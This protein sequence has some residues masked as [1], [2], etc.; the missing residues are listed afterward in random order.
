[1][2]PIS[3]SYLLAGL[4]LAVVVLAV[5]LA[6]RKKVDTVGL[7]QRLDVLERG[8]ERL[9]AA[10]RGEL[11]SLRTNAERSA[12][13]QRLELAESVKA[14][15]D[16]M[17][18]S[19]EQVTSLHRDK[20]DE[21]SAALAEMTRANDRRMQ[22]L[23]EVVDKNLA[24]MWRRTEASLEKIRDK[25]DK[26]L[27]ETLEQRLGESFR[28]VSERLEQV[29]HGL[30]EMQELA[31]GVGDLKK[32]LTNVKARGTWGEV[33][34][35]MLLE[36][37]LAP[38]QFERN[39]AVRPGA[40]ERVEFAIRLPGAGEGGRVLLPV[41]S[42]FPVADFQRLVD[43][44]ERGD[45]GA[46]A[47][48]RKALLKAVEENAK[49]ISDKYVVPPFTTDFAVMYL[50]VEGLYAEVLREPGVVEE[51]QVKHRVTVAGPST[52]AAFLNSLQM[53]FTTLAIQ[54]RAREVWS[55]LKAVKEDMSRFGRD[56]EAAARHIEKAG[57]TVM[58]AAR[59][60][61][62]IERRLSDVETLSCRLQDAAQQ[63]EGGTKGS[64][65][66]GDE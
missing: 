66:T 7:A 3:S 59:R 17:R 55:L 29:Q 12:R 50:P 10:L 41:D 20:L 37:V 64:P 21:V 8:L 19:L 36:Q 14:A 43:A 4:V 61:S 34:L 32:V 23:R 60:T 11:E 5:L 63:V 35:G 44:S 2:E 33:Q 54:E 39:A 45:P 28:L 6:R 47:K 16:T 56:L 15:G 18:A 1:M 25:V 57:R 51:L 58:S 38:G 53:G 42:K 52:L 65:G 27:H 9:E 24:E 31:R 40:S 22:D 13:E 62:K 48:A 46:E 26:E 30:G 49:K